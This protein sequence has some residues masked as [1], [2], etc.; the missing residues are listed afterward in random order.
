MRTERIQT[1]DHLVA[2]RA[3]RQA[4]LVT[5]QQALGAGLSPKAIKVRIARGRWSP[6]RRK[7]YT[8]NGVPPTWEQA[9]VAACL[10]AGN[11][12][13]AS[14][15][16][17]A[18]VWGLPM[19]DEPGI[20]L[21]LPEPCQVAVDG[22]IGHRTTAFLNADRTDHGG[23]AVTSAA[24][25]VVDL[26]GQLRA[27]ALGSA[28]DLLLRKGRLR[29]IDLQRCAG[30]L[31]PAPGRRPA[32]LHEVLAARLPGYDPGD[33]D[34]ETRVVR[35]I[36]VAGLPA[37]VMGQR[38]RVGGR[39]YRIDLAWPN[40]MLA[41]ELDGWDTHRTRSAFDHDRARANDLVVLGWGL[42][43]FTTAMNDEAIVAVIAQALA[44]DQAV[45]ELGA[46]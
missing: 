10:A 23:I 42:L 30:R 26:S 6:V 31:P 15:G 44:A 22:V 38:V 7:V 45:R 41:V 28:T 37:P 34:F 5:F 21:L 9:V 17:A 39:S 18:R 11:G 14:H 1:P 8:I 27:R 32:V 25:T 16:T 24:R 46:P 3:Q 36:L 35:A 4:G 13:V 19:G 12:A 33:S 2:E 43:R 29:L 40:A 20:H